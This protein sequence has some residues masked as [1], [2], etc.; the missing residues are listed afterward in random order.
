[1][2][3]LLFVFQFAY[4]QNLVKGKITDQDK[5][6]LA[7]ATIY[8]PELNKGTVSDKDGFYIMTDLPSG[9]L[10]IQFSFIGYRNKIV[11]IIPEAPETEINVTLETTTIRT[12]EIVVSGGSSST[13]HEN[14]VKIEALKLDL[15]EVK[16]TPNLTEILMKVPGI[17]MISKGEGVAKPVIRGLSMNDILVLNNGVRFE[18]YQYSDHHPLGITEFGIADIEIIKG[19]SSLL[20][21]SD[22]IGGVIN[23]IKEKPAPVGTLEGDYNLQL[24]SNTLGITNNFGIKGSSK[25]YYGGLRFGQKSNADFLQGSGIFVPNT[26]FNEYAIGLSTGITG[27]RGSFKIYYDYSRQNAGLAE[28]E[29]FD[30]VTA[31][32]RKA[33]VF[34]Q[35]FNTHLLS[36]RNKLYLGKFKLDLNS[37]YQNTELIHFGQPGVNEIQMRLSTLTYESRFYLPS[38]KNSEYI[39]GYQGMYQDNLN[40]FNRETILL[41]DASIINNSLFFLIQ[42]TF[43]QKLRLQTGMRL[44][45]REIITKTVGVQEEAGFRSAVRKHYDSFSG[46]AGAT[47]NISRDFLLRANFAS[48]YRTPNLAEL[49]S[50]GQHE[51][52]YEIGNQTLVPEK[53]YE[54]DISMH[55]HI[56]NFSFDVSGFYNSINDH[57]FI[58]PTGDSTSGGVHIYRYDQADSYLYGIETNL[59]FHPQAI[60]WLHFMGTFSS[61]TGKQS[62]GTYLPFIPANKLYFEIRGEKKELIVLQKAFIMISS[63]IISDQNKTA[64]EESQTKHYTL[65]DLTLGGQIKAN[66]QNI[67]I[68]LGA[69][70]VFDTKYVDHLSTLKEVNY[71]NPG[72]NI[73]LSV[74]I[75]FSIIAQ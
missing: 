70:N 36:S 43:F 21:G 19:P 9:K 10:N 7:G 55:Y 59:H 67:S 46:S 40:R 27:K 15:Y 35:Q 37:A 17:E 20:Y 11:T 39:I 29:A 71:F 58:H 69:T 1:F 68:S 13:Q 51:T 41:P 61:V 75:P 56:D 28:P 48:A 25:H 65:F 52:R 62:G 57:I 30:F 73:T 12:D 64:P 31:R 42:K 34:Y 50:N 54:E 63:D 72:R 5:L 32:G 44:D 23:F 24:F 6:P 2:S 38:D 53:S 74:R 18:N 26:R 8:F 49:T 33:E 66:D 16:A 47:Y 60:K 14:A 22:A 4:A 45:S 3:A